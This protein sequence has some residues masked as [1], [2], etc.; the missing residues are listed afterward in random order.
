MSKSRKLIALA[1]GA[2]AVCAIVVAQA[3]AGTTIWKGNGIDDPQMTVKFERVK[4]SGEPAKIREFEVQN[5]FFD[6]QGAS[7][8]RSGLI[9]H[10]TISK[11]HNGQFSYSAIT[12]NSEHTVKYNTSI[13]GEF[14][15]SI[16][17]KGTVKQKRTL[18]SNP[19]TYCVSARE[20]WKALKQ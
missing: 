11:V 12:Y 5:M 3:F 20:P 4:V 6:C 10:G 13:D 2:V 15:S 17:A 19:D 1:L 18:V 8:F 7:D 9:R 16:K 14:V